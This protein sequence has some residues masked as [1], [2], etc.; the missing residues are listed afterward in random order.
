MLC[1]LWQ[2]SAAQKWCI[3]AH[4]DELA[5]NYINARMPV[6]AGN[7][8]TIYGSLCV[9]TFAQDYGVW[10]KLCRSQQFLIEYML[11]F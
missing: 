9:H 1:G 11:D 6:L 8:I 10:L 7:D 4:F 3:Q 2:V 5:D